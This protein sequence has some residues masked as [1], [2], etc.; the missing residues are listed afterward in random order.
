MDHFENAYLIV[1]VS[2]L[3]NPIVH[4][5]LTF[6]IF[7]I[8]RQKYKKVTKMS[9]FIS[10]YRIFKHG[11]IV[12]SSRSS[13]INVF[14][15]KKIIF[16]HN[17]KMADR[18]W[19]RFDKTSYVFH[20][21]HHILFLISLIM[22]ELYKN[23]CHDYYLVLIRGLSVKYRAYLYISAFTLFFIIGRVASFKVIPTW[24][25]NTVPAMFP[26]LETVL[27]LTFRD[28]LEYARRI[29]FNRRFVIESLSF[30]WFFEFWKQ[31]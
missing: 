7:S 27:E 31:P 8:C 4:F 26:L 22:H 3:S 2:A 10:L 14:T 5:T 17:F 29:I 1:F 6:A 9:I 23:E 18:T 13:D 21:F 15:K 19:S 25:N 28:R 16:V 24:L 11:S 20:V 12:W 30:E